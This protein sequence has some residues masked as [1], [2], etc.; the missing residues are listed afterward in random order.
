[1]LL[2]VILVLVGNTA[3]AYEPVY[4]S[5][6][7][8]FGNLKYTL[9]VKVRDVT[10]DRGELGQFHD[11]NIYKYE[12]GRPGGE[13][14]LNIQSE[15][16]WGCRTFGPSGGLSDFLNASPVKVD[17]PYIVWHI[18]T[19]V[20]CGMRTRTS[21]NYILINTNSDTYTI[22]STVAPDGMLLVQNEDKFFIY[23]HYQDW[24]KGG[25]STSLL[26]PLKEQ[27]HPSSGRAKLSL[28]DVKDGKIYNEKSFGSWGTYKGFMNVFYLGL[29]QREP[30][31]TKYALEELYKPKELAGYSEFICGGPSC[32]PNQNTS[33][34][35]FERVHQKLT[36][37]PETLEE[38]RKM[39]TIFEDLFPL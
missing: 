22:T 37:L 30:S 26:I 35:W 34:E 5:F 32:K 23:S 6:V 12:K 1:M 39:G 21:A 20:H 19:D 36:G 17:G 14:L 13:I 38:I 25:T 28:G 31:L 3:T 27:I 10:N 18:F 7:Q 9:K 8:T 15:K 4:G 33:K 2:V 24:G 29:I 16:I 11:L